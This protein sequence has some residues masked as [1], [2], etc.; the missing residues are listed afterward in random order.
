[1]PGGMVSMN[2]DLS[3]IGAY[4]GAIRGTLEAQEAPAMSEQI[5][6]RMMTVLKK[7]S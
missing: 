4:V 5:I 6:N 1:M 7:S 2:A 3:G